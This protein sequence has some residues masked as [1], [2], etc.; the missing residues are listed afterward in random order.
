MNL[1]IYFDGSC[2]PGA[3]GTAA[4][5]YI[6]KNDAGETLH[7]ASGRIGAGKAMSSNLAEFAGLYYAMLWVHEHSPDAEA[8]FM[9]DSSLVI[10]H[11]RG[12]SKAR[13]G[14]YLPWYRKAIRLA[15]PH[16]EAGKWDFRW[17]NRAMNSEADEL[18][19]HYRY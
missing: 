6:V 1:T 9:G 14:R 13:K 7:T 12:E 3:N 18:S 8:V 5:G 19:Q 11:M 16:I 15:S 4:Y 10:T 2:G 17:I